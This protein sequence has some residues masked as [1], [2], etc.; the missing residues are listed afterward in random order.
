MF[1]TDLDI[2]IIYDWYEQSLEENGVLMTTMNMNIKLKRLLSRNSGP[3]SEHDVYIELD[4]F[5]V[6]VRS[7]CSESMDLNWKGLK[8]S[9]ENKRAKGRITWKKHECVICM[10]STPP[11]IVLDNCKC[12]FHRHCINTEL[13]YRSVC[14]VCSSSINIYQI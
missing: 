10:S 9:S 14:P 13:K 5:D 11:K 8:P 4:D 2:N 12:T 3:I 1:P 7:E 6:L